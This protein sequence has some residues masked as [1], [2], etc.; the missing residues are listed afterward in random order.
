ME[1]VSFSVGVVALASLFSTCVE[2]F[3]YLEASKSH[4]RDYEILLTQLDVEKTKLLQWGERMG[5]R[6]E[7]G[8][9][10]RLNDPH[11]RPT[12][13]RVLNCIKML[14][15]DSDN[16]AQKYG[17]K[18]VER[19]DHAV[20]ATAIVSRLRMRLFAD[21]NERFAAR[22]MNQQKRTG[23]L[24]K[25]KLAI[26]DCNKFKDLVAQLSTFVGSLNDLVPATETTKRRLI[27]EDVE[28]LVG[29]LSSLRLLRD[30]C[31]DVNPEWSYAATQ[32]VEL[33]ELATTDRRNIEEWV[34]DTTFSDEYQEA[35]PSG[36]F[37]SRSW[38]PEANSAERQRYLEEILSH[39]DSR[40]LSFVHNFVSPRLK[41]D[42]FTFLPDEL[43]FRVSLCFV[44]S[45]HRIRT[46][47]HARFYHLLTT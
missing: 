24:A 16:L 47:Y 23:F 27:Q 17:L 28:S 40:Q 42:P 30:A 38:N 21:S 22:I 32:Q 2:C 19:I 1:A 4:G 26:H 11:T 7:E 18:P 46:H 45:L 14:L 36:D 15:T 25:T 35:G 10:D 20:E 41:K 37:F 29:D 3:G 13:E 8:R 44:C 31:E 5:L 6:C 12:L 39:C 34:Q 33:S 43:C 9:D